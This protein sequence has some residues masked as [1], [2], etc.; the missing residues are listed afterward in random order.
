MCKQVY[1]RKRI[2]I[3]DID[4]GRRTVWAS[5]TVCKDQNSAERLGLLL[6]RDL[7]SKSICNV[8]V[9]VK[10]LTPKKKNK[11]TL[12]IIGHVSLEVRHAEVKPEWCL[13]YFSTRAEI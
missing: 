1:V 11:K 8:K 6:C 10:P 7:W 9:G 13:K 5:G 4:R 12:S 2:E 3:N